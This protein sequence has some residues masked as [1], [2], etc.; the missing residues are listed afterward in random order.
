GTGTITYTWN[1]AASTQDLTN[2]PAGAYSVTIT[3]ANNCSF[4]LTATVTQPTAALNATSVT[5]NVACFGGLTGAV[6]VTVT[7]GTPNY[8]YNWGGGITTQNRTAVAA[9]AYNLTVTDANNCTFNLSAS[10][11]Q[12]A[13]AL[14]VTATATP[15]SGNNGTAT[16]TATGGTTVYSYS[17][18]TS[19]AQTT[20][21]ATGLAPGTYAVV[22]TDANSCTASAAATVIVVG[23]SEIEN[24]INNFSLFPNPANDKLSVMMDLKNVRS[25]Q[26]N[27]IDITGKI[28]YA[29]KESVNGKVSH[30]INVSEFTPGVYIIEAIAD[31]QA[32]RRTFN[33]VR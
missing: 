10:V 6:T 31:K 24:E 28:V 27:V 32:V 4:G 33:I 13:A 18:N 14:S 19:P 1:P 15:S 20:A 2:V 11:S 8:S 16:A 5:T 12:P 25:V 22:V 9:G 7:G 23:V 26:L 30:E 29:V 3:D 21:T 17:W